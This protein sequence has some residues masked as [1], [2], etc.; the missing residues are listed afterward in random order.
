[1]D[2][3][4]QDSSFQRVSLRSTSTRLYV[5]VEIDYS[6]GKEGRIEGGNEEGLPFQGSE[7]ELVGGNYAPPGLFTLV[8][9]IRTGA[10]G[11]R[12]GEAR[13]EGG[14]RT[15]DGRHASHRS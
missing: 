3:S 12:R 10:S 11:E 4:G 8:K 6:H 5:L 14:S 2:A 7:R 1:M 9:P 13:R 15:L